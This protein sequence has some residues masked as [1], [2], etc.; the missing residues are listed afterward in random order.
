MTI[1]SIVARNAM[2]YPNN[3]ALVFGDK[4]LTWRMLNNRVNRLANAFLSLGLTKG[5]KVAM[6]SENHP[7]CVEANYR[8]I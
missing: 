7:A 4:R 2:Q 6:L 5:D 1:G 3:E 8:K